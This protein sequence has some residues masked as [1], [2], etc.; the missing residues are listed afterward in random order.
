MFV[1]YRCAF[2]VRL[3]ETTSS[4]A[5]SKDIP[6]HTIIDPLPKLSLVTKLHCA[7]HSP[8]CLYTITCPS[9]LYRQNLNS[10]K[11][12]TLRQSCSTQL[13]CSN[14]KFKRALWRAAVNLDPVAGLLGLGCIW[15][16]FSHFLT[17]FSP[18]RSAYCLTCDLEVGEQWETL[19]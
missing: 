10:S 19:L 11:A 6:I 15:S 4:V 2:K 3:T 18:R 8:G 7:Y 12:K 17:V 13:T 9:D 5:T 16:S 14:A 1:L